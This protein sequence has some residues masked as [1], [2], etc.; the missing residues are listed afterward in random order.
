[1]TQGGVILTTTSIMRGSTDTSLAGSVRGMSGTLREEDPT[2]SGL[3]GST[4]AWL[5]TMWAIAA[6]GS[7][8]RMISSS[9]TTRTTWAGIWPITC[10]WEP[11]FT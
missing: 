7:G 6:T 4:S 1:M 10:G 5:P 11:T 8:I 9:M 3:A 2:V